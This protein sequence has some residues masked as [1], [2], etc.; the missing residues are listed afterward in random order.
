MKNV[1]E[2]LVHFILRKKLAKNEQENV[3]HFNL[4][5]KL[6]KVHSKIQRRA[7]AVGINC[8]QQATRQRFTAGKYHEKRITNKQAT[9]Q[10]FTIFKYKMN[11]LFATLR[12]W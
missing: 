5:E 11:V 3:V 4:N 9:R 1:Q 10:Q 12:R 8:L 2:N 6:I 7:M